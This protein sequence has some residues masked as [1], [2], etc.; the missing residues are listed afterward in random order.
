LQKSPASLKLGEMLVRPHSLWDVLVSK[1]IATYTEIFLQIGQL[2]RNL[3][4][5][6]NFFTHKD[7]HTHVKLKTSSLGVSVLVEPRNVLV[8]STLDIQWY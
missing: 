5:L 1:L 4:L 7:R 2:V 6:R 8:S 3:S